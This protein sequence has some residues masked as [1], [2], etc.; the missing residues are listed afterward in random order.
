MTVVTRDVYLPGVTASYTVARLALHA[1]LKCAPFAT[2][3]APFEDGCS[4]ITQEAVNMA[5]KAYVPASHP[6][7]FSMVMHVL[8]WTCNRVTDLHMMPCLASSLCTKLGGLRI[9][10]LNLGVLTV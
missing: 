8:S 3:L 10:N 4:K 5:Y 2:L 1:C 7:F 6:R 9:D